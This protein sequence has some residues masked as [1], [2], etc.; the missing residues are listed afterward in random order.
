MELPD[1]QRV[2]GGTIVLSGLAAMLAGLG[3]IGLA[4]V[5]VGTALLLVG[6]EKRR[7]SLRADAGRPASSTSRKRP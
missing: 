2:V 3:P 7:A 6:W 5:Q 4:A 1:V